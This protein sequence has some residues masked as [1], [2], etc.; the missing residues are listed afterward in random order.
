MLT[1][2][3]VIKV[4]GKLLTSLVQGLYG[5]NFENHNTFGAKIK[6]YFPLSTKLFIKNEVPL[7]IDAFQHQ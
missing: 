6:P 7:F 2:L 3:L 1:P 5:N 4:V